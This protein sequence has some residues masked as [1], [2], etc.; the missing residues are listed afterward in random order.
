MRYNL[1]LLNVPN[2]ILTTGFLPFVG[3][4]NKF[5]TCLLN[6]NIII[7][8]LIKYLLSAYAYLYKERDILRDK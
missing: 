6:N 3:S 4:C 5:D 2:E 7:E 1:R 8:C